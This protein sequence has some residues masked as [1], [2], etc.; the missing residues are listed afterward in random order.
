MRSL[1]L[2]AL[3]L[4]ACSPSADRRSPVD[5]TAEDSGLIDTGDT[6]PYT[7]PTGFIGSPCETA[8]DCGPDGAVCLTEGFPDGM[9]SLPCDQYCPDDDD[10]PMTFCVTED[11]LPA[12]GAALGDGA[13]SS[14]CDFGHFPETGCRE[15][16][17]CA[18][19][20]R[21]NEPGA[22]AFTCLP[23][24]ETELSECYSELAARG[25]AFEP[26]II[27]DRSPDSHPSLTC[28]VEDPLY[29]LGAVHDV[30]LAYSMN[31]GAARTLAACDMAHSLTDTIDDVGDRGV[32][33]LRHYGTYNCR[34]ISGTSR[35]SRHAYGDAIDIFGFEFADG[36][37]YTLAG[38][39]EHDTTTPQ[40]QAAQ[41]MYDAAYRWHDAAYWNII[42]TPNY[43]DAHDDHF[44]VDLTPG[45]DTIRS[46]G[47]FIGTNETGD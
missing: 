43:N 40:S 24:A 22:Q 37:L 17:G 31:D 2:L 14:R 27:A 46:R 9:C 34:V 10:H 36:S 42:L 23:N 5:D 18:V 15:D 4:V 1:T 6:G 11:E 41:F 21:A 38:D 39:W 20:T 29:I 32:T 30:E 19:A 13:C 45:S 8:S 35:L 44:H 33:I 47:T 26:A 28:H 25:V 3:F 16:Y 7:G 12:A